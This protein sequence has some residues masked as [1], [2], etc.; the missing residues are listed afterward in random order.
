[1]VCIQRTQNFHSL[2]VAWLC[3]QNFLK[4]LGS[5]YWT[6]AIKRKRST[7]IIFNVEKK[8]PAKKI[9]VKSKQTIGHSNLILI[10]CHDILS[11]H[12]SKVGSTCNSNLMS[13]FVTVHKHILVKSDVVV[14]PYIPWEGHELPTVAE[15][16]EIGRILFTE[17][18]VTKSLFKNWIMSAVLS[19]Q[20][21]VAMKELI[22][23]QWKHPLIVTATLDGH[24]QNS[25]NNI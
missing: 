17:S 23:W 19:L 16:V 5:L 13:C 11:E 24:G 9:S 7:K 2:I 12:W 21:C 6:N 15:T 10:R 3:F 22:C 25:F 14:S 20:Q 18:L 1:M 8:N 4:A